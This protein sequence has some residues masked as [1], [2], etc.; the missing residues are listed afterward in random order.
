MIMLK[1]V[2]INPHYCGFDY[3]V[4]SLQSNNKTNTNN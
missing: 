1:F 2:K 4:I 3:L